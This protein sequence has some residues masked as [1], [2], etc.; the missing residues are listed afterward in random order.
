M[1]KKLSSIVALLFIACTI[2]T[3]GAQL[4]KANDAIRPD[5][6]GSGSL[7]IHKHWAED[8]SQ[9]GAEGN[10]KELT[11]DDAVTNPPV[12]GVKF[13]I[14]LLTPTDEDTPDT[15]PSE[16]DGA[17]YSVN[18]N[19]TVLTITVKDE[20]NNDT[21]T[22]TMGEKQ[23][24]TTNASGIYKFENL[25]GFY[26]VEEDLANS[27]PEV[28]GKDVNIA[29]PAKP[30]I[31]SVPMTTPDGTGWFKDVHVYPKNQGMTP[32]K[33]VN[34]GGANSVNI[35]DELDFGIK[36]AI[37]TDIGEPNYTVFN[38]NDTLDEA[39]TYSADSAG[40][41]VY[42]ADG[43]GGWD[44]LSVPATTES[45]ANY[46][47][48]YNA[49][50]LS[51]VFTEAGRKVLADAMAGDGKYTHVG[52]EF[53]ATV[54]ENV[55]S[56]PNYTVK[57]KG[58][59]EWKNTPGDETKKTTTPETETN[60]GDIDIDKVDQDGDALLG[61]EF[62]IAKDEEDAQDG[63]YIKVEVDEDENVKITD[64]VYPGE[65]GY[66]GA[67]NWVIRPHASTDDLGVI[68][69]TFYASKFQGLQTHTGVDDDKVALKYYVVETKTKEGY[70]LLDGPVEVDFDEE[71]TAHIVTKEIVNSQG[72]KL[73]NT[74]SLGMIL[75]TIIGIILIGLAILMFLPKKR[76]S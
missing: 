73:P 20:T 37:P 76:R 18:E 23:T 44:K 7:T 63:N 49:S 68:D 6:E 11:G 61:A 43:S 8:N 67:L 13:N 40:V 75:L 39:L 70:N 60:T 10:G 59:I 12:K 31:V 2:I 3:G 16:K 54:N 30:F 34:N 48:S 29:T 53:N 41:Y 35:G 32:E 14:Y 33:T 47:I 38:I 5:I 28:D 45:V 1:K 9:V 46:T 71:N 55:L 19:R 62:Q 15:P 4:V 69:G 66:A 24:G 22:Y 52:I 21:Y 65:A 36:V 58:E 42:K 64:L 57:N 25:E 17:V 56:K 27:D 26:Y 72:F 51:V 74:G 50:K